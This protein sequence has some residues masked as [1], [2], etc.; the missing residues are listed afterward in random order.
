MVA[1]GTSASLSLD[2][3]ATVVTFRATDNDGLSSS[4]SVT[5]AVAAPD[6]NVLPEVSIAGGDRTTT[7]VMTQQGRLFPYQEQPQT[8]TEVC[9]RP[10]GLSV[11]AWWRRATRLTFHSVTV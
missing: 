2:D 3:G 9:R 7:T 6:A 5:I 8:Q 4:K 11:A 1:T 10:N